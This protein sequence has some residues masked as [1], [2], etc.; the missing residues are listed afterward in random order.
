MAQ[1]VLLHHHHPTQPDHYD[2]LIDQPQWTDEHRLITFRTH[3]RPDRHHEFIAQKAPL[4]RAIY[5]TYQG[6]LSENRGTVT[7]VATGIVRDLR[8]T[9]E[10]LTCRLSWGAADLLCTATPQP[11]KPDHWRFLLTPHNQP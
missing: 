9:P 7:S 11:A 6:P 1:T 2:W 10:H 5:L 3:L 8:V 4:H